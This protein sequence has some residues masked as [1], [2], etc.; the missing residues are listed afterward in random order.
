MPPACHL[1]R[2]YQS[3]PPCERT[4]PSNDLERSLRDPALQ[5]LACVSGGK[6]TVAD[7][8]LAFGRQLGQRRILVEHVEQRIVAKAVC[9]AR[10]QLDYPRQHTLDQL[11]RTAGPCQG[12]RADKPCEPRVERHI[13]E[14]FEQ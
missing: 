2:V 1:T 3:L 13:L 6:G 9:A 10:R 7:L 12:D 8:V 14:L 5:Y 4:T 11:Q